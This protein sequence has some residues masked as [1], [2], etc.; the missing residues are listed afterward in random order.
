[1]EIV[2]EILQ[3]K[4]H[5]NHK[6]CEVEVEA[7]SWL[8]KIYNPVL[9]SY[10]FSSFS[11]KKICV[12]LCYLHER[13]KKN[14]ICKL[15]SGMFKTV[16]VGAKMGISEC[17]H[18][19]HMN[20]WNCSTFTDSPHVFG[21]LLKINS[22]EKAYVYGVSAAGVAY[23][24]TRACSRGELTECGCDHQ[25]RQRPTRGRWDWGGCSEDLR[26]G[27]YF[28][29]EFVDARENKNSAEGLMNLHNNEAGRR[30][31]RSK[32]ELVCKCHGVSGSCSMRVC[33]RKMGDFRTIGDSLHTRF[34][35]ATSV[36]L[37]NRKKRKKLRPRRKG[38]K[39]PTRRDFVY[40]QESPDYCEHN[41]KLGIL[42]TGGR[43]CNKTS[44]G[45]DGCRI[46]C[47]GRG[48]Q[49]M[50]RTVT[51]KCNCRFIWCCKV[52]C[53]MCQVERMEHYCN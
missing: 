25:I 7:A 45:M 39:R 47:C 53:D 35:S 18:Q 41:E 46:L 51:E 32:M 13:R 15:W 22:R 6:R 1:M 12:C 21:H 16:S 36:K 5:A 8:Q 40:L 48:Y 9:A 26:F 34:E 42:G 30:A 11:G 17:Q 2:Q 28:S 20:R 37:V 27:E 31:I 33:W 3:L 23:S 52:E 14:Q 10:F 24:V 19:F 4:M 43:I 29:K 44:W 38:F 49:T 50:Q